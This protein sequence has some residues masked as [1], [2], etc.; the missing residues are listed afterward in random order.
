MKH[1][2]HCHC[3]FRDQLTKFKA[4]KLGLLGGFLIVAHLLFHVAE[5]LLLPV[6]IASFSHHDAEAVAELNTEEMQE[7]THNTASDQLNILHGDFFQTIEDYSL[8]STL[9]LAE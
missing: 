5:C 3:H 1:R 8:T 9:M 7:T 2:H 4:G 6:I